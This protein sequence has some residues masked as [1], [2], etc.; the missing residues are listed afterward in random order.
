LS[1]EVSEMNRSAR[2]DEPELVSSKKLKRTLITPHMEEE[3]SPGKNLIYCS[4]FQLAWNQLQDDVV[5][6]EVRLAGA[7]RMAELLNKRLS[8]KNDL[9]DDCY[10]AMAGECTPELV[11]GLN[12]ALKDKFG[13]EAPPELR[14]NIPQLLKPILAYAYL[15]K[16]LEFPEKFQVLPRPM[17]FESDGKKSYVKAFGYSWIELDEKYHKLR[18]QVS[19]MAGRTSF[20]DS[21]D[22]TDEDDDSPETKLLKQIFHE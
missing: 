21:V 18:E 20:F 9:S 22:R 15:S 6:E 1:E 19:V 11:E 4:T 2:S 16:N 17:M 8:T 10:L 12:K 5:K 3:I 14:A 7:P 13:K